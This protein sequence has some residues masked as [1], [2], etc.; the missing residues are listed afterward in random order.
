MGWLGNVTKSLLGY[1]LFISYSRKEAGA[2][3]RELARLL[4][5]GGFGCFIDDEELPAGQELP[6]TLQKAARRSKALLLVGTDRALGRHYVDL[7]VRS[8][9]D[10]GR[11]V[12]P[13]NVGHVLEHGPWPALRE[14]KWI[15][16]SPEAL[17]A[18]RPSASVISEIERTKRLIRRRRIA[19][20]AL[21]VIGTAMAA[22]AG[23]ALLQ[24][25]EATRQATI[26]AERRRVTDVLALKD[27]ALE[28]LSVEPE[29]GVLLALEAARAAEGLDRTTGIAV[30]KALRQAIQV[31]RVRQLV[32]VPGVDSGTLGLLL[33]SG[34]VLLARRTGTLEH[35]SVEAGRAR[36]EEP[37]ELGPTTAISADAAARRVL[38]VDGMGSARVTNLDARTVSA[39]PRE[40]QA[41]LGVAISADGRRAAGFDRRGQVIVWDAD[42]GRTVALLRGEG[43][44]AI[45]LSPDGVRVAVGEF[46]GH[47]RI[48]DLEQHDVVEYQASATN[49]RVAFITFASSGTRLAIGHRDNTVVVRDLA[50]DAPL[51]LRGHHGDARAIDFSDDAARLITG[52]DDGIVRL[53]SLADGKQDY[54][55]A[56]HSRPVVGV[57]FVPGSDFAVSVSADGAARLWY[58]GATLEIAHLTTR[59]ASE[60]AFS[61]D[62]ARLVAA[63][64]DDQASVWDARRW[65]MVST[66]H[67]RG[68]QPLYRIAISPDGSQLISRGDRVPKLWDASTGALIGTMPGHG[69]KQISAVLYGPRAQWLA[70]AGG[71]GTIRVRDAAGTPLRELRSG[72][73]R[74]IDELVRSPGGTVIAAGTAGGLVEFW[75][76]DGWTRIGQ[77]ALGRSPRGM[78]IRVDAGGWYLLERGVGVQPVLWKADERRRIRM[79]DGL[80]VQ[81]DAVALSPDGRMAAGTD[82]NDVLR[83]WDALDGTELATLQGDGDVAFSPDG[84]QLA[85]VQADGTVQVYAATHGELVRVA[86]DTRAV[87]ALTAKECLEY[88]SRGCPR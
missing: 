26:A 29:L 87:R 12:I 47:V 19:V 75:E 77:L 84:R 72:D 20:A 53:W 22:A 71:D 11:R 37:F 63:G 27:A 16:E 76:S 81:V 23:W 9:L 85:A 33:G 13:I 73:D 28:R 18:G 60:L 10:S 57:G 49:N 70:T 36:R 54:A 17:D 79:F 24:Q 21:V 56:G 48:H 25:I 45:A 1:D 50:T 59:R 62:G 38:S 83:L 7:E 67:D 31:S 51:T 82:R 8:F 41:L 78:R 64:V 14:A 65:T 69:G 4:E 80:S 52:G 5:V 15:D 66:I 30:D 68:A 39:V 32:A 40:A 55:L 6:V 34:R 86:R 88:L 2:Y 44:S 74:A 35:W 46:S 58:V 43:V 3:A 61:D 42:S